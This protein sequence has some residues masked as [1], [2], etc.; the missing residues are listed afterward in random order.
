MTN[1]I[2]I[3]KEVY[4]ARN[5]R[6][7]NFIGKEKPILAA[8]TKKR[9]TMELSKFTILDIYGVERIPLSGEYTA[10]SLS[11]TFIENW[12][13]YY[14]CHKCGRWDYCKYAKPYPANPDRS[15]D[16]KCGVAV[17]SLR[18]FVKATFGI[19]EQLEG[20]EKIQEYLDGAFFFCKFIFDAEQS[21]GMC[22]N[23][24][25]RKYFGEYAPM[26]FGRM[27]HLRESLNRLGS[28]WK[29]IPE[30]RAKHP[31]LFVEG[32]SEKEFLDELRK[33]HFSCFLDLNVDVYGGKGNRRLK[34]IQMLLAKYVEQG[35]VI[36]AQGDADGEN[37]DIFRGLIKAGS[38]SEDNIFVFKY[39]FESSLPLDLLCVVLKVME[40]L[41][42]MSEEEFE[43]QLGND[44]IS[45]VQKLKE[46]F[47]IDIKPHKLEFANTVAR[48]LNHPRAIWWQNEK[49]MNKSELGQFLRFIQ[50]IV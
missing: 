32:Y 43:T 33:S 10:E 26:L 46:K 6:D 29:G 30:F 18:N 39:D 15:E 49:F 17:D 36:Y 19:L 11:E 40:F 27:T 37:T 3:K 45:V 5:S 4:I 1:K 35:Y 50:R 9:K 13:P 48:V 12:I 34:R 31:V 2:Q 21:I 23:E 20:E 8:N 16:I 44:D 14:E 47:S 25:F 38:I 24:D 22:M 41:E 42:D 28:H 7:G